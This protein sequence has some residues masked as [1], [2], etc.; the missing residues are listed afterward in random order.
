MG[1]K[2][3]LGRGGR[4]AGSD[5]IFIPRPAPVLYRRGLIGTGLA[6]TAIFSF[7]FLWLQ[8]LKISLKLLFRFLDICLIKPH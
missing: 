2:V 8:F 6:C 1:L 7:L 4:G 3:G 5:G